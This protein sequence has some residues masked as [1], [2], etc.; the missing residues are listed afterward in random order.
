MTYLSLAEEHL[1]RYCLIDASLSLPEVQ[2]AIQQ[3]I[4]AFLETS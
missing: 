4:T 1:E 3:V 2:L